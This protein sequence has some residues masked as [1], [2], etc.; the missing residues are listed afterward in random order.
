MFVAVDEEPLA[1]DVELPLPLPPPLLP[2]DP[3]AIAASPEITAV[4]VLLGKG[5]F[6]A[7][8]QE[9]IIDLAL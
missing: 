3:V 9:I 4:V 5:L 2:V 7:A 8:W 6:A 1:E